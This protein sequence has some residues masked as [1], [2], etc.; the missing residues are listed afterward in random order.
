[1]TFTIENF[2]GEF[3]FAK[4]NAIEALAL[5]TII[6]FDDFDM[7]VKMIDTILEKIEVNCGSDW[8]PVKEKAHNVYYPVGIENNVFA[9]NELVEKFLNDYLKPL[10]T[11]S[12]ASNQ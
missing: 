2:D 3:R 1:M 10:F 11:K 7:S 5:R 9:I 8:L 6:N 12:S 4:M